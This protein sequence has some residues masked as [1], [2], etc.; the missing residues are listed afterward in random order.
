MAFIYRDGM[1]SHCG[2]ASMCQS[3]D[4]GADDGNSFAFHGRSPRAKRISISASASG[5]SAMVSIT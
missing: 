1:A 2:G 3:D 4:A 5:R